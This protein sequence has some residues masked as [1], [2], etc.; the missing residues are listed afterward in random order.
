MGLKEREERSKVQ[1]LGLQVA[2][3]EQAE[4]ALVVLAVVVLS[5]PLPTLLL[6][7]EQQLVCYQ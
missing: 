6:L 5:P 4:R 2:Q 7:L 3:A 1:R